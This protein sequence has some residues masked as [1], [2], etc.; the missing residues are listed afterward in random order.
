MGS[1]GSRI[2]KLAR[3]GVRSSKP[4]SLTCCMSMRWDEMETYLFFFFHFLPNWSLILGDLCSP[5]PFETEVFFEVLKVAPSTH[6]PPHQPQYGYLV[7][8]SDTTALVGLV[9][10][11]IILKLVMCHCSDSL[12]YC[13]ALGK[14]PLHTNTLPSPLPDACVCTSIVLVCRMVSQDSTNSKSFTIA[15]RS[16]SFLTCCSLCRWILVFFFPINACYWEISAHLH[17][18]KPNDFVVLQGFQVAPTTHDPSSSTLWL[19]S[20]CLF[21]LIQMVWPNGGSCR[22]LQSPLVMSLPWSPAQF[23]AL[24]LSNKSSHSG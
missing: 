3:I 18:S 8:Y 15:A 11:G 16:R 17:P 1:Q 12:P 23:L 21:S 6:H 10:C 13:L 24:V 5:S 4:A 9:D 22:L 7:W 20:V 14:P 19:P 2:S